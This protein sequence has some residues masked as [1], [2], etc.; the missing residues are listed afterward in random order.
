MLHKITKNNKNNI[1]NIF[2]NNMSALSYLSI[3][4]YCLFNTTK[5]KFYLNE[6]MLNNEKIEK[7]EIDIRTQQEKTIYIL[8]NT[9]TKKYEKTENVMLLKDNN[10]LALYKINHF[11]SNI[12]VEDLRSSLLNNLIFK[13]SANNSSNEGS[14]E[15]TQIVQEVDL[16]EVNEKISNIEAKQQWLNSK[17]DDLNNEYVGSFNQLNFIND[18][19]NSMSEQNHELS[20]KIDSFENY[21]MTSEENDNNHTRLISNLT[22]TLT[23]LNNNYLITKSSVQTLQTQMQKIDENARRLEQQYEDE[24]EVYVLNGSYTGS[25]RTSHLKSD[26]KMFEIEPRRSFAFPIVKAQL[27][28]SGIIANPAFYVEIKDYKIYV[29]TTTANYDSF[30]ANNKVS[31]QVTIN[32]DWKR[33]EAEH[34]S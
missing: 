29:H 21:K 30:F 13:T 2:N 32:E 1:N 19:I 14:S 22:Q 25:I 17:V 16:S 12:E 3:F 18:T 24:T 4:S 9:A 23:N 33:Y 7:A 8:F 27:I 28:T 26:F 15:T 34:G 20:Q 31:I 5:D 10:K 11:V 6:F